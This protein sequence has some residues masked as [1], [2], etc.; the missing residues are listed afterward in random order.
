M[1]ESSYPF[2]F[3]HLYGPLVTPQWGFWAQHRATENPAPVFRARGQRMRIK[4]VQ[5]NE[6]VPRPTHGGCQ[7]TLCKKA[8]LRETN[9]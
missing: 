6:K 2:I 5:T 4:E 9:A 3:D 8:V 1:K 7:P